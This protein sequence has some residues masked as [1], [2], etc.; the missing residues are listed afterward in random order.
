MTEAGF[1][2]GAWRTGAEAAVQRAAEELR[3][4]LHQAV[5]RLDPFPP[6]P[7]ALFTYA[8]EAEPEAAAHADRGCVVVA[9][10]GEL[11]ELVLGMEPAGPDE[12]ADPV[13][14]RREE[15]RRLDLH[16]RDYIVY[17]YNALTRVLELLREQEGE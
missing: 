11:Y 10:D 7:G 3:V 15:M 4:L 8:I 5:A 1:D 9:P 6:F 16:P 12:L 14:I 2:I 17:A 13:A